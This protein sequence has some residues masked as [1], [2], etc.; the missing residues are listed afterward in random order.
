MVVQGQQ[1][2]WGSC[3]CFDFSPAGLREALPCSAT[4]KT[5]SGGP[6]SCLPYP[7]KLFLNGHEWAKQQPLKG[8][9]EI[10]D[11]DLRRIDLRAPFPAAVLEVSDQFLLGSSRF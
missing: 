2:P 8:H 3:A 10:V 1:A 4:S 6:P 5:S 7:V 9:H 11:L